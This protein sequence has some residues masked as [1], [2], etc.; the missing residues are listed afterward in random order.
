MV[1]S[2]WLVIKSML[3]KLKLKA[4]IGYI[5]SS[6]LTQA[7]QNLGT[8]PFFELHDKAS[9]K[10]FEKHSEII[11]YKGRPLYVIDGSNLNLPSCKSLSEAFGR[12][13]S[14]ATKK[15]LPQASFT[16]LELLNTDWIVD[17]KLD[18]F[19][20]GELNQ[21][22]ELVS[23]NL[24]KGDFLLADRLYFDTKWYAS[25][26]GREIDFMFRVNCDRYKSCTPES[27]EKILLQRKKSGNIDL[28]VDLRIAGTDTNLPKTISVRYMEIPRKGA[29]TLF[30]M[31]TLSVKELSQ[32][33]AVELYRMRWEIETD[34]RFFKGQDHLPVIL[35]KTEETVKQ[36]VIMKVIAHNSLRFIQSDACLKV[37]AGDLPKNN[38][39]IVKKMTKWKFKSSTHSLG[40]RPVDLKYLKTLSIVSGFILQSIV[41]CGDICAKDSRSLLAE[42]ARSEILVY[43]NRSF[44]RRKKKFGT[45]GNVKAQDQR[46]AARKKASEDEP[47][48]TQ[49]FDSQCIL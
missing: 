19:K 14:S 35:S 13:N 39:K 42:I 1:D 20:A 40:L 46:R 30:F 27:R 44:P 11:Q 2:K 21:A 8:A 25:M 6:A 5:T 28:T 10:H 34:F 43:P 15:S 24:S 49:F 22:K 48:K 3:Y 7:R 38:P 4:K 16:V 33:E 31:T 37:R 9:T 23:E 29:Q 47:T 26:V 45:K 41:N 18:N 17:Y 12:P 32:Q 36:E